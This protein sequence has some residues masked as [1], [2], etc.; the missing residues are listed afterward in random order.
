MNQIVHFNLIA[1]NCHFKLT[2]ESF[3]LYICKILHENIAQSSVTNFTFPV[4][5]SLINQSKFSTEEIN[6]ELIC[7]SVKREMSN[8]AHL[9]WY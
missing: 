1:R 8:L 9:S 2:V 5:S 3:Y 4:C 7:K 6:L